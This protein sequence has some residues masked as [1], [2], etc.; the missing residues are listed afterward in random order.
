MIPGANLP[1]EFGLTQTV[2]SL[3]GNRAAALVER[4]RGQLASCDSIN[5]DVTRIARTETKNTSLTA[6]RVE[7][8]VTDDR[9]V[10]FLMAILR[11]KTSVSQLGFL[12]NAPSDLPLNSFVA[13]AQRALNRLGELRGPRK[14]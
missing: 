5:T 9:T 8:E 7:L 10:I 1:K 14:S 3:P 11:D 4:V 2:G 13:L 6:W 12:P